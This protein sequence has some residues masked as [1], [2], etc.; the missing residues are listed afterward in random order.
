MND[1]KKQ[2]SLTFFDPPIN[3]N[4]T[5]NEQHVPEWSFAASRQCIIPGDGYNA[6][7]GVCK[8]N[9]DCIS[10]SNG[11]LITFSFHIEAPDEIKCYLFYE[12]QA[13]RFYAQ[14]ILQVFPRLFDME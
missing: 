9:L 7:E 13:S 12:G 10:K 14:D 2:D 3:C 11:Q 6:G 1:D 4:T 5:P 8:N